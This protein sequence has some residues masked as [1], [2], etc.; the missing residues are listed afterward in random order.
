MG[1]ARIG[2]KDQLAVDIRQEMRFAGILC[3]LI[4]AH[5]ACSMA[6]GLFSF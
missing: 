1:L 6:G 4:S 5:P 2:E 3:I